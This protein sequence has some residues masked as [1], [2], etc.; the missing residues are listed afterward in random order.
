MFPQRQR[1][2]GYRHIDL[3]ILVTHGGIVHMHLVR[4]AFQKLAR[5][6]LNLE[7]GWLPRWM[8]ISTDFQQFN[9]ITPEKKCHQKEREP[10]SKSGHMLAIWCYLH[11]FSVFVTQKSW[12]ASAAATDMTQRYQ[13]PRISVHHGERRWG[14]F[15]WV[16]CG[17]GQ[18]QKFIPE[19]LVI[20]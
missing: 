18:N 11:V 2:N 1:T 13:A 20:F 19:I 15:P 12:N 14:L 5:A 9:G 16:R 10:L 7:I 4:K 8:W 6:H 3:F 17:S